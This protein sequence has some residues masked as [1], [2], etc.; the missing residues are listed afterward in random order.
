MKKASEH[1]KLLQKEPALL[2]TMADRLSPGD[3]DVFHKDVFQE[4][5]KND[6]KVLPKLKPLQRYQYLSILII[7]SVT[8]VTHSWLFFEQHIMK[9]IVMPAIVVLSE[10]FWGD[11]AAAQSTPAAKPDEAKTDPAK[12]DPAKPD[13]PKTDTKAET[14]EVKKNDNDQFDPL[15]LDESRVKVLLSLHEREK[16]LNKLQGMDSTKESAKKALDVQLDKKIAE[17]KELK[18]VIETLALSNNGEVAKNIKK[19]VA[20][21]EAMKP[22]AAARIFNELPQQVL[23]DL[24]KQMSPKKSSTILALM[25][26]EKAKALTD[27]IAFAPSVPEPVD[28]KKGT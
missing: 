21:Y 15:S 6:K 22:E 20:I 3:F 19:M 27:M 18:K 13:A 4:K 24:F 14:S 8:F 26:V 7:F 23:V 9:M 11:T 2:A 28:T 1:K 16:E 17:L 25:T 5:A 10:A 12:T